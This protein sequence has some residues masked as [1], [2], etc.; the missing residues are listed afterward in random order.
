MIQALTNLRRRY[1]GDGLNLYTYVSNNPVKYI[2]PS[3][4]AKCTAAQNIDKALDG[5]QMLLDIAGFIPALGNIAVL[6]NLG[7]SIFRGNVLD[8]V[9]SAIAILLALKNAMAT[10]NIV[11]SEVL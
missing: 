6:L 2:D 3:G 11:R 8:T 5:L 7:I 4:L 1:R 10:Q 9:F